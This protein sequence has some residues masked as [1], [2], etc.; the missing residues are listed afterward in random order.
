MTYKKIDFRGIILESFQKS[1]SLKPCQ[2][3]CFLNICRYKKSN[4]LAWAI[5]K[6]NFWGGHL[7]APG[8]WYLHT[9]SNYL[10]LKYLPIKTKKLSP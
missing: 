2:K 5:Q 1:R 9:M 4:D 6:T 10:L 8:G 3:I 7:G